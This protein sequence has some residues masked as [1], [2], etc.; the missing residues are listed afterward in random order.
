MSADPTRITPADAAGYEWGTTALNTWH[1]LARYWRNRKSAR[2]HHRS[3][4]SMTSPAAA[5]ALSP[6][7]WRMPIALMIVT[8]INWFD[9][10]AMSLALPKIA[11]EHGWSTTEIGANGA[12]LISL[13][14]LGYGLANLI[15]SPI[16]E[17]FGPRKALIVSV[18]A[19][20]IATALNAPF[21]ATVAALAGLRFLLGVAEGIHF[22]MASGIVSRWFPL[23]ERS[24]ANGLFI[25]GIQVAVVAGPFIMVPLIGRFG[26]RGMFLALG[27]AGLLIALPAVIGILRDDGPYAQ[28]DGGD[29][30][31]LWTVFRNPSYWLVLIA[32]VLSNIIAYGIL[33]WLPTYLAKGRQVPFADLAASASIP[34]WLGALSIP[35]WA[36]LGDRTGRRAQFASVGCGLAGI[37]VYFAAHSPGLALTVAFLAGS[38][39]FQNAYQTAEFA[40]VQRILPPERVGAAT[41]LYNG[42]SIILG[43][44][45]GTALVGKVVEATGSYDSGL[46]VVVV[47]GLLNFVVLGLLYRRIKY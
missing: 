12:R 40:L 15:L 31:P 1:G 47:A 45:G 46:M 24:R 43:G 39:F 13:F 23:N 32:G 25:L 14:F 6:I 35:V 7:R 2:Y 41:G 34:F 21:G 19:F 38:L 37:G 30:A 5:P 33:T 42:I 9:R 20:S 16:A 29:G 8:T 11:E 27:A 28:G 18:I 22:P 26:W 36:I 10:S 3:I 4:A 17:R 44:A